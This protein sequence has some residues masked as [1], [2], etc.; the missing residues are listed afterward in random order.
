MAVK[1]T[2]KETKVETTKKE[3]TTKK[4]PAKRA[5]TTRKPRELKGKKVFGDLV[6]YGKQQG[7][8]AVKKMKKPLIAAATIVGIAGTALVVNE[9]RKDN[10]SLDEIPNGDVVDIPAED[11]NVVDDE[12]TEEETDTEETTE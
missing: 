11:Y 7:K 1:E 2:K 6:A 3:T 5:T 4:A 10:Q 8:K 9:V 12:T